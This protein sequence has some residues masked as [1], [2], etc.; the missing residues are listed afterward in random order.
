MLGKKCQRRYDDSLIK[1][2]IVSVNYLNGFISSNLNEFYDLNGSIH[3]EFVQ[4][5]S[6]ITSESSMVFWITLVFTIDQLIRAIVT[7]ILFF[8]KK[9]SSEFIIVL[10]LSCLIVVL[11]QFLYF[12]IYC[13]FNKIFFKKLQNFSGFKTNKF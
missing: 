4:N 9:K 10:I 7:S 11:I 8:I 12:F 13:K 5:I 3:E 6:I 1:K 2:S